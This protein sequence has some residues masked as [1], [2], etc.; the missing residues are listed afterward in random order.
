MIECYSD[1]C[2]MEAVIECKICY[3]EYCKLHYEEDH[4]KGVCIHK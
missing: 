1:G 2:E 3:G 4:P